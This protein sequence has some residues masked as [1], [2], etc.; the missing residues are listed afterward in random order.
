MH[1]LAKVKAL[2]KETWPDDG[3]A[4]STAPVT[5]GKTPRKRKGKGTA[6][7]EEDD[8]DASVAAG[9]TAKKSKVKK[10]DDEGFDV[11]IG[12]TNVQATPT[13]KG[14]KGTG[15]PKGRATKKKA[16]TAVGGVK[17]IKT[18]ED[19]NGGVKASGDDVESAVEAYEDEMVEFAIES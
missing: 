18:E 11:G 5:P 2:A 13:K 7:A 17:D 12:E 14:G 1:R 6:S 9:S 16:D 4:S 19:V 15:K 3:A 8:D 10:E